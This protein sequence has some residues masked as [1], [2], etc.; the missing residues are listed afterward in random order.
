VTLTLPPMVHTGR[1][2]RVRAALDVEA[3][4]V[5]D[6]TNVRWLT[7]FTG[8]SAWV[9]LLPDRMVL[10]TDGRY[11][12]RAG[13]ELAAA[14]VQADIVVGTTKERVREL[15]VEAVRG[16]AAVGADPT[17]LSHAAWCDYERDLPLVEVTGAVEAARRQKDAAE[18]ARIEIACRIADDALAA[19]APM[20]AHEP[21]E[22]NVRDELDHHM[23]TLGAAGPSYPT[24]VASGPV[25]G[26]RPHHE[27][28]SRPIVGGDTVVIDVGALVDGYHSDMT[29]SYVVGEPSAEQLDRYALVLSAQL[30]GLA[31]VRA[32]AGAR[33]VDTAARDV[34]ERAG[35]G[36]WYLHSTGHG[37]G[38]LIHEDPFETRTST[39]TLLVGDVVTVEPGLY[40]QGF[41]GFRVEDLVVVT[42]DGCRILTHTPKDTPCLPSPPTT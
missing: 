36:D 40:R 10:G 34:F 31:A 27:P 23:R 7:G 15:L 14:G 22:A 13:S 1:A 2:D 4:L 42:D 6:L 17:T 12:E 33:D 38:L 20:L 29:R 19:V 35:Y 32:G 5:T 9:A 24:I 16:V 37:V 30:A 18:V 8:S 41:G 39:Q 21:T 3:L 26:A 25:N 11:A 28:E